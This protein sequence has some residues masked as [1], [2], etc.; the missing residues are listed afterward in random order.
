MFSLHGYSQVEILSFKGKGF[1]VLQ[2]V[3]KE[4]D[5]WKRGKGI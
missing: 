2:D 4:G 1:S 3:S 5:L